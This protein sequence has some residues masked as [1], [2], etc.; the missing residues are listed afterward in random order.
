M[1]EAKIKTP[2]TPLPF[3]PFFSCRFCHGFYHYLGGTDLFAGVRG[4]DWSFTWIERLLIAG[5]SLFFYLS[6][7]LWPSN[8]AFIYP[9]WRID[10]SEW[11]QYLFPVGAMGLIV[12]LWAARH[13]LG[14]GPLVA[15]LFFIL[16][17]LP[18]LG[19]INF[20]G[21]RFA[22]VT[23]HH[24]YLPSI[25]VI[26]LFASMITSFRLTPSRKYVIGVVTLGLWFALTLVTWRHSYLF[27]DV[28]RLFEDTIRKNPTCWV[29]YHNLAYEMTKQGKHDKALQYE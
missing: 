15:I 2:E 18:V 5:R 28:V 23:D 4:A 29:A 10:P 12:G 14:R 25:G 3:N 24:Q 26:A 7:L 21:M 8:L 16:S 13:K 20:Y 22:F 6:K 11:W 1:V 9:K 27:Q 17:I 19:F